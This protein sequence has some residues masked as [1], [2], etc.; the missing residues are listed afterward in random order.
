[1]K[2]IGLNGFGRIGRA[3]TRINNGE[4]FEIVAVNDINPDIYNMA[5][6]LK[7]DS[8]YGGY[9]DVKVLDD[10]NLEIAGQVVRVY[11]EDAVHRVPW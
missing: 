7:Y 5:Y 11:H 9:H 1:M 3:I 2:K 10:Y 6:L 4:Q 8:V